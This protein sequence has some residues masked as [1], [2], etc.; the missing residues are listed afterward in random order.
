MNTSAALAA[1]RRASVSPCPVLLPSVR[2]PLALAI[3][4]TG[5]RG[6]DEGAGAE[7]RVRPG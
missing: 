3:L 5:A 7:A 2:P 6:F 1:A 4:G